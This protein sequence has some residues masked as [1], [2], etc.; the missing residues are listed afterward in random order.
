MIEASWVCE[1]L[2]DYQGGQAE[3]EIGAGSLLHCYNSPALCVSH[4]QCE[5][6]PV[7]ASQPQLTLPVQAMLHHK[8]Q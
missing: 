4:S 2:L 3:Q 6:A 7:N 8:A 5:S 1:V